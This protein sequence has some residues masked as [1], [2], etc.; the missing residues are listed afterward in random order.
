MTNQIKTIQLSTGTWVLVEVPKEAI[1]FRMGDITHDL[2][3]HNGIECFI[4]LPKMSKSTRRAIIGKASE[5]TEDQWKQIVET[6][7]SYRW[8]VRRGIQRFKNYR[9]EAPFETAKESGLSLLKSQGMEPETTVI[10]KQ[11]S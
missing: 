10:L 9:V 4:V 11:Q 7:P 5:L 6:F 1:N 2:Y 8:G 3:Y